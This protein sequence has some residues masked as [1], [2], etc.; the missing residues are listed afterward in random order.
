MS[1]RVLD[2]DRPRARG[3][4]APLAWDRPAVAFLV[5]LAL[6]AGGA[7]LLFVVF[8]AWLEDSF[9]LSIVALGG[10][11]VLIGLAELFG[12]GATVAVTDRLGKRRSLVVGLIVAAVGYLLLVPWE[13]SQVGG[14]AALAIGLAGFE[15]A[16]LAS[17]PLQTEIKPHAR[18][19]FLSW[20]VVTMGSARAVGAAVAPVLY[21]AFGI[22][23][24]AVVAAAA[25]VLA[26]AALVMWV[27]EPPT[28]R[29]VVAGS[30]EPRKE[31]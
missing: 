17:V 19:R 9:G 18:V 7:E 1:L 15:F 3:D 29:S 26:I 20:A 11:S 5:V 4:V 22:G 28:R 23:G 13:G 27:D 16:I 8:G 25:N 31:P 21:G 14:L 30:V 12:E 2:A 6:F 24:N 10:T